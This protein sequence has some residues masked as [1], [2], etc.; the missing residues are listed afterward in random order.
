MDLGALPHLLNSLTL[1]DSVLAVV[2]LLAGTVAGWTLTNYHDQ[3]I[4]TRKLK[5]NRKS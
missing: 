4:R 2:A 1:D 3:Q 5:V